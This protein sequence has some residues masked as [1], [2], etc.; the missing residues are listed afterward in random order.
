M[1]DTLLHLIKVYDEA[2]KLACNHCKKALDLINCEWGMD[3]E[4]YI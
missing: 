1:M 2:T 4:E 3:A